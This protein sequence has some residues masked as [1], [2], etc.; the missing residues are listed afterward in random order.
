M[1]VTKT[2]TWKNFV[3]GIL[4][5]KQLRNKQ[6]DL[7]EEERHRESK[8]LSKICSK[9]NLQEHQSV[10]RDLVSYL[11]QI[12]HVR[13]KDS[14]RSVHVWQKCAV[15]L[16][17]PTDFVFTCITAVNLAEGRIL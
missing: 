16:F 1:S 14:K 10:K 17:G 8:N 12:F 2:C 11:D 15:L 3:P 9:F 7:Q 13:S 4:A 5:D 6:R